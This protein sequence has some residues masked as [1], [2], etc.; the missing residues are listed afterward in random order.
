MNDK[1][2]EKTSSVRPTEIVPPAQPGESFP[3]IGCLLIIRLHLQN[4]RMAGDWLSLYRGIRR[5]ER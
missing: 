3:G 5:C 1:I 2:G 4:L